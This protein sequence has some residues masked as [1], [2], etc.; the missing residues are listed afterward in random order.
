MR[1]FKCIKPVRDWHTVG[2]TYEFHEDRLYDNV[3]G[4]LIDDWEDSHWVKLEDTEEFMF[5][6]HFTE[7]ENVTTI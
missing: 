3:D 1:L 7:V 2:A 4:Y 5:H 6:E